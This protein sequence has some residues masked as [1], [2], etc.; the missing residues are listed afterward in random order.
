MVRR[1]RQPGCACPAEP[2]GAAE[3]GRSG[4]HRSKRAS[5]SLHA[6]LTKTIQRHARKTLQRCSCGPRAHRAAH[7]RLFCTA[8][9]EAGKVPVQL[10]IHAG[11]SAAAFQAPVV[12]R[13]MYWTVWSHRCHTTGP[14]ERSSLRRRCA[15]RVDLQQA[16]ATLYMMTQ[17]CGPRQA[18]GPAQLRRP[19][20]PIPQPSLTGAP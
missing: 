3:Q 11:P 12:C 8:D 9:R 16:S 20:Q 14:T 15:L 1:E 19:P 17:R 2:T 13:L 7:S 10:H 4:A 5:V 6:S 18:S